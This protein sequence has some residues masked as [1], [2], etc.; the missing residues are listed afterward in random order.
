MKKKSLYSSF[1][2]VLTFAFAVAAFVS[3]SLFSACSSREGADTTARVVPESEFADWESKYATTLNEA[4][5]GDSGHYGLAGVSEGAG[6]EGEISYSFC[7]ID[8]N[9][10]AE[11]VFLDGDLDVVGLYSIAGGNPINLRSEDDDVVVVGDSSNVSIYSNG[12]IGIYW[13]AHAGDLPYGLNYYKINQDSTA[14]ELV[15]EASRGYDRPPDDDDSFDKG[16]TPAGT[17][18]NKNLVVKRL[19]KI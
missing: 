15:V 16:Y 2:L 14:L 4:A 9:G 17:V 10:V 19:N 7:D 18:I 11:L 12:E 3:A 6:A 5:N 1:P 8:G 13:E